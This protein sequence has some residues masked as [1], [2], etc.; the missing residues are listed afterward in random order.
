MAA[1]DGGGGG[2]KEIGGCRDEEDGMVIVIVDYIWCLHL[3][4]VRNRDR[5]L[6]EELGCAIMQMI[7]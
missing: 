6:N 1:G 2:E 4:R 5:F 7:L 3:W